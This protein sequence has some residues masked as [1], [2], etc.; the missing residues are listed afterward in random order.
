MKGIEGVP[1][2][3]ILTIVV[4]VT[5]I[6]AVVGFMSSLSG[7]VT[8]LGGGTVKTMNATAMEKI[9]ETGLQE[10]QCCKACKTLDS[11][12]YSSCNLDC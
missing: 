8:S 12:K 4:A 9:C 2:Q 1:L 11:N 7:A 6:A 5:I 10:G 3:Y